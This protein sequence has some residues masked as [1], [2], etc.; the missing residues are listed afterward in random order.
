MP[1]T[2]EERRERM[3]VKQQRYRDRHRSEYNAYMREYWRKYNDLKYPPRKWTTEE[4]LLVL[5]HSMTDKEL[6]RLLKRSWE[7]VKSRRKDLKA[8]FQMHLA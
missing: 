3:R 2:A 5:E 8:K 6:A 4:D 7:S 1:L